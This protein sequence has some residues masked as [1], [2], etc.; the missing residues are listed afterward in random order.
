MRSSDEHEGAFVMEVW[1][2]RVD[3]Q[4][5]F[6]LFPLEPCAAVRASSDRL[7]ADSHSCT[8]KHQPPMQSR[9]LLRLLFLPLL[10][11]SSK[12]GVQ[13]CPEI[14]EPLVAQH[15]SGSRPLCWI[16]LEHLADQVAALLRHMYALWDEW[17]GCNSPLFL[18]ELL[19]LPVHFLGGLVSVALSQQ[20]PLLDARVRS[21]SHSLQLCV[22][23]ARCRIFLFLVMRFQLC[24]PLPQ[25]A[26]IR[27]EGVVVLALVRKEQRL[28]VDD[29]L[30]V[31]SHFVPKLLQGQQPLFVNLLELFVELF[32]L[33][34]LPHMTRHHLHF[35][36]DLEDYHL[37]INLPVMERGRACEDFNHQDAERPD[38]N[39]EA[40]VRRTEKELW[41]SVETGDD[42]SREL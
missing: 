16:H 20:N 21:L 11:L 40:V 1:G 33:D 23:L 30:L 3:R 12:I 7:Q 22:M 8:P 18:Q 5:H 39:L 24:T 19:H 26:H 4:P 37:L 32:F 36:E 31:G 38:V 28:F 42:A 9:P 13:L 17:V 15:L 41:R 2:K 10:P 14:V 6:L 29:T 35:L 25:R 34:L 27:F